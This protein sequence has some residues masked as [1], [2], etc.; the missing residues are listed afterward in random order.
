[1]RRIAKPMWRA[2]LLSSALA[3]AFVAAP[4]AAQTRIP[5]VTRLVKQFVGLEDELAA[6][7]RSG[8]AAVIDRLV[9]EDFEQR[10]AAR[11]GEPLPR[12][13]WLQRDAKA[14]AAFS[15]IEQMAVHE[16][17]ELMIVS[18]LRSDAGR[19]HSQFVVDVWKRQP[20]GTRLLIRYLSPAPA[21]TGPAIKKKY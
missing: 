1:M 6:A 2:L 10:D 18:F 15:E 5:T 13:D 12:V 7:L 8:D 17:G 19:Q 3:L 4:A 9:A 14:G 20:D 16:H 21:T 11:P